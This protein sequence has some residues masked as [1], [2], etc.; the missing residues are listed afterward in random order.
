MGPVGVWISTDSLSLIIITLSAFNIDCMAI[1]L[2][3]KNEAMPTAVAPSRFLE[4]LWACLTIF[5]GSAP[6]GGDH[7]DHSYRVPCVLSSVRALRLRAVCAIIRTCPRVTLDRRL[8][9]NPR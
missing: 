2:D 5:R 6:P 7:V 3:S 1:Y 9:P 8:R 4:S